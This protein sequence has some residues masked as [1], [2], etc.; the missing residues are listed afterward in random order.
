MSVGIKNDGK[1]ETTTWVPED[2]VN[3][4]SDEVRIKQRS[5]LWYLVFIGFSVNYMIRININISI[6]DMIDKNLR[7][8]SNVIA[9]ECF[10]ITHE[11]SLDSLTEV[12]KNSS[13]YTN[14]AE[15]KRFPTLERKI[16]DALGV[17]FVLISSCFATFKL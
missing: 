12:Q 2:F 14:A 15:S 7:K 4:F 9:S 1:L 13:N 11:S 10:E 16:L 3:E 8:S 5:I 17:K 6:V